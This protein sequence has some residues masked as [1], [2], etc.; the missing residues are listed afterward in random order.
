MYLSSPFRVIRTTP[1]ASE[2]LSLQEAKLFLR[3]DHDTEDTAICQMIKA[4]REVAEEIMNRSLI[5]QRWQLTLQDALPAYFTIPYGPVTQIISLSKLDADGSTSTLNNDIIMIAAD[6]ETL[7]CTAPQTAK[8]FI[9]T[10]EAGMSENAA[11]VPASLRQNM[12][13][14]VAYLY[15]FRTLGDA[16]RIHDITRLYAP[17]RKISL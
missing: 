2:P 8:Q 3:I 6:S 14:H 1:P 12:L 9:I 15:G 17:W 11:G 10:Y 7:E 4:A 13:Q 5:T 16:E